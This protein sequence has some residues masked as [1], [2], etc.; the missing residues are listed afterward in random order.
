[1]IEATNAI[2][3]DT[4]PCE[5]T[6]KDVTRIKAFT[7]AVDGGVIPVPTLGQYL[8]FPDDYLTVTSTIPAGNA[9]GLKVSTRWY[10]HTTN[11]TF[12]IHSPT[13]A[14]RRLK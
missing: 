3:S 6:V 8:W 13:A 11:E 5:I 7:L 2:G 4:L 1:M 9:A 12:N 14:N 10:N